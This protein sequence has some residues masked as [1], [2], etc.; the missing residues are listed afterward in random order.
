MLGRPPGFARRGERPDD[1]VGL[2]FDDDLDPSL[3]RT[4][5]RCDGLPIAGRPIAPLD[6]LR[7]R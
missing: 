2:R 6:P 4:P 7:V 3:R 5:A 1:Q